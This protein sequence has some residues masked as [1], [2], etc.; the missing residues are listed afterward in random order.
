MVRESSTGRG[1]LRK[2][3]HKIPSQETSK[4]FFYLTRRERERK[5]PGNDPYLA[6]PS[7]PNLPR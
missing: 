6:S 4:L 1:L 2:I 3:H 5:L 7:C